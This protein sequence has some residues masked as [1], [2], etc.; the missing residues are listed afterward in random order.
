MKRRDL[1]L[2][3][4]AV[5]AASSLG[6]PRP[7]AA[8]PRTLRMVESGGKS[9]ES[10]EA[11]YV[12]PFTEKTG[13]KV[14]REAPN[15]LGKLRAMVESGNVTAALFELG[16]PNVAQAKA[17]GLLD[18]LDWQEINP[19]PIFP[20]ARDDY[21]MGF[22]YFST[23]MAWRTDAKAPATW[24]DFFDAAR[25][26]GKRALP[27]YPHYVL[28]FVLIADGV[29]LDQ[30]F[31]LDV[32]RAFRKLESVKKSISIWWKAGA[33]PPQL[34]ADNEVQYAIS[35]STRVVDE[36]KAHFTYQQGMYDISCLVV[37]KGTKPAE[38]ALAMKLLH[39][40]T[41]PQNQVRAS[42]ILKLGGNSPDLEKLVGAE[43]FASFPT[44]A[45]NKAGQFR[46]DGEWW[47]ANGDAINKRWEAFKLTL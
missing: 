46:Q 36:P 24:S 3:L 12:K 10:I 30:V 29:A 26:P 39:E 23:V 32:D 37:P 2:A 14:V 28:P 44:A 35:W 34:L 22:Q 6:L 16:S 17:L 27:D 8:Q 42:Q 9:G 43:K 13:V 18:K 33:Q 11:A 25:F 4:P 45:K 1:T 20:E 31:P 40:V 7:A 41:V 5:V 15:Q 21:A 47:R 38:K 19:L